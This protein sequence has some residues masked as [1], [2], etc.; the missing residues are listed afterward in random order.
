MSK[1][2][3]REITIAE[4]KGVFS[5]F[6]KTLSGETEYDFESLSALRKLFSKERA[7]MLHVIKYDSPGSIYSLA[8]K[9]GRTFRAVKTDLN[10]LER[11]GFIEFIQEKT[12]NRKRL[13][14]EL[15]VD[16]MTIH[17]KI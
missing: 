15:V 8:K 16:T 13:K 2:K 9:L 5:L 3:T 7:R 14:P 4:S 1:S 12:K 10:L 6:T 11:F 17:F